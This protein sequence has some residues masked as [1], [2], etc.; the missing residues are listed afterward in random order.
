MGDPFLGVRQTRATSGIFLTLISI[1]PHREIDFCDIVVTIVGGRFGAES[2]DQPGYS[3]TG[4]K[5]TRYFP[6]DISFIDRIDKAALIEFS[7]QTRID[8]FLHGHVCDLAIEFRNKLDEA[9]A[10]I[11]RVCFRI[12]T[13]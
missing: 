5:L 3:I 11:G 10:F 2:R 9:V 8:N 4:L 12:L 1:P 13:A 7:H 6:R